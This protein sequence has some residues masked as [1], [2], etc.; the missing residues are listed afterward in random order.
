MKESNAMPAAGIVLAAFGTTRPE[1]LAGITRVLQ[2]VEA[3]LPA[4]R[5]SLAFTSNQVRRV[6]QRRATDPDWLQDHPE[7]PPQVLAVRGPLAAIAELQDRGLRDIVV[8]PLH[9]YA[10]EEFEDLKSYLAGLNAIRTIKPRWQPFRRLALGRPAL[11]QPG[12]QFPYRDDLERAAQ[13]LASDLDAARRRGA[14]LVYAGHGNPFFSTGVYQ[15]LQAVLR[16]LHDYPPVVVGVVEG[17]WSLDYVLEELGRLKTKQVLLKPLMLVAGEH[18]RCDLCGEEPE[19]W[20]KV[21]QEQGY[22]VECD[23]RGL[24]ENPAWAELYLENLCQA[25]QA[26]EIDLQGGG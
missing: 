9:I 13:A 5:V 21:L 14:A 18:A 26:A 17:S 15:E 11:G 10:G 24:G 20:R 4:C 3:A 23:L 22:E 8:Q 1:A 6:W 7:V 16:R 19:S 25:A 2:R 12:P